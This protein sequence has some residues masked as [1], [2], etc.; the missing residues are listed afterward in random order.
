MFIGVQ[1]APSDVEDDR[2]ALFHERNFSSPVCIN[3]YIPRSLLLLLLA[4]VSS[5][6]PVV[7]RLAINTDGRCR[8]SV[9][10]TAIAGRIELVANDRFLPAIDSSN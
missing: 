10:T 1:V 9:L 5:R 3:N 6:F 2:P 8:R 4:P 7:S